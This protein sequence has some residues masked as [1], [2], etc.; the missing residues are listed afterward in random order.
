MVSSTT[1]PRAIEAT[2]M[3]LKAVVGYA[4]S[5]KPSTTG[6]DIS[7]QVNARTFKVLPIK[8]KH[9]GVV[10]VAGL[11]KVLVPGNNVG[12]ESIP[13]PYRIPERRQC[14]SRV[15]CR[16]QSGQKPGGIALQIA[17]FRSKI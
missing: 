14:V 16:L 3:A 11:E 8:A 12:S 10:R 13:K 4:E 17:A 6:G 7:V 2:V 15:H 9:T 5:A 1:M